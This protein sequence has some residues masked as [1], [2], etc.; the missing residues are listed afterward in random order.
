[1]EIEAFFE[2]VRE[3]A[4]D[5][6]LSHEPRPWGFMV[7]GDAGLVEALVGPRE[8]GTWE[9]YSD[10]SSEFEPGTT[11]QFETSDVGPWGDGPGCRPFSEKRETHGGLLRGTLEEILEQF[12]KIVSAE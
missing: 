8:D 4:E 11:V 12:A 7:W 9:Y 3:L 6:D 10:V 2:K 5:P 1:M